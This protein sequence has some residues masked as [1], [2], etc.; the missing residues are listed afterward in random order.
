MTVSSISPEHTN[1]GLFDRVP[2]GCLW[3][4]H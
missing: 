3:T 4:I 1:Y 2:I